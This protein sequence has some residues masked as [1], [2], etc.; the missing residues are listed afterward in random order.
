MA[1]FNLAFQNS[2][3]QQAPSTVKI[4]RTVCADS[5]NSE[6]MDCPYNSFSKWVY[7]CAEAT[8]SKNFNLNTFLKKIG[9]PMQSLIKSYISC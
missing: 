7:T 8:F 9:A 6:W 1:W 5:E 4:Y 3:V 2:K